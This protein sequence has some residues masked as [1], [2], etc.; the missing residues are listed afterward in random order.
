MKATQF[1]EVHQQAGEE[2]AI[3]EGGM[4][5]LT[6]SSP[7]IPLNKI[8]REVGAIDDSVKI[9][10]SDPF[11]TVDYNGKTAYLYRDIEKLRKHFLDISPEDEK[12]INKLCSDLKNSPSCVCLLSM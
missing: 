3:F 7:K 4:H 8:W 9:H 1:L 5:W 6:G 12:E 11:I 10:K 2:K